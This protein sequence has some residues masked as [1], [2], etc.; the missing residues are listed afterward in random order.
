MLFNNEFLKRY[1]ILIK[2]IWDK[3]SY[4]VNLIFTD[5]IIIN[6]FSGSIKNELKK[7]DG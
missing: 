1:V 6:I 4:Q 2:Q 7:K 3:N 5:K